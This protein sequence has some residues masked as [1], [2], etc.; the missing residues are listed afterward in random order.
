MKV[1]VKCSAGC[2]LAG[3]SIEIRDETDVKVT[4]ATLGQIPWSGTAALYWAEVEL[5]DPANEGICYWL[6]KF[7][8]T[9]TPVP[10]EGATLVFSFLTVKPPE[11]AVLVKVIEKDTRAGLENAEV[12]LGVYKARSDQTGCARIEVPSGTYDLNAWKLGYQAV[13]KTVNVAG[14]LTVQIEV[15]AVPEAAAPYWM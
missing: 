4:G 15:V 13:A 10:H 5:P 6:A 14:N 1:G 12:R 2:R 7:V 8:P 11:H 9:D 3:E